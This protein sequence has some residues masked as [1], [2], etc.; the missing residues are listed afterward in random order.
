MLSLFQ[1]SKGGYAKNKGRGTTSSFMK[2]D[3]VFI[4]SP[5]FGG[6]SSYSVK[7]YLE[8]ASHYNGSNNGDLSATYKT[9]SKRGWRSKSTL[10]KSIKELVDK[11]F[12]VVTRHGGKNCCNLYALTR[13]GIDDC[14][15][16]IECKPNRVPTNAWKQ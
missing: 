6:L 3:H 15:G 1:V 16:K 2:L 5:E 7:L 8:I 11:D 12:I 14:N 13:Y 4:K 9:L 10:S